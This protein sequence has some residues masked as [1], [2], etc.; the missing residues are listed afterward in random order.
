MIKFLTV[1][2]GIFILG[3]GLFAGLCVLTITFFPRQDPMPL[4]AQE[5]L[6]IMFL[7]F[8]CLLMIVL[9]IGVFLRENWARVAVLV[10]FFL[11]LLAGVSSISVSI[12]A[13]RLPSEIL[14]QVIFLIVIPLFFLVFFNA[15]T[16]KGLFASRRG[17]V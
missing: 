10:M 17:G 11:A 1:L 9:S 14:L 16:V 7:V 12:L 13:R 8:M 2:S 3:T 4:T 6:V 5:L 15:R